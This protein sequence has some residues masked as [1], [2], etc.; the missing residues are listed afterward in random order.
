MTTLAGGAPGPRLEPAPLRE[1]VEA[2]FTG[3]ANRPDPAVGQ[4]GNLSHRR[5]H[6]PSVLVAD[7]AA[8]GAATDTDWTAWHLMQQVH[9]ADVAVVGADT[10]RGAELRGVD[11]LVTGEQDRVLAVGAADCVPLLLASDRAVAAA[12]VGRPGLAAGAVDAALDALP[13]DGVVAVVGPAIGGCCYEV[14]A[15]MRDEVTTRSHPAAASSTTWGTPSLDIPAAVLAQL[16]DRGVDARRVGG[17]TRCGDGWFS[18]RADPAAGRHLG[19][20]VRR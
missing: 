10:P 9:G 14:P 20:V 3:R 11:V 6:V 1:G 5:P 4:A 19:L 12:H 18:H 8:V 15:E 2:W 16:A 17:C 7:R 13:G